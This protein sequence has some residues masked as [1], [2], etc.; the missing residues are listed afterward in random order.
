MKIKSSATGALITNMLDVFYHVS[1]DQLL[2][3]L[4]TE[5]VAD[6]PYSETSPF[7]SM[8]SPANIVRSRKKNKASP[9]KL[10]NFHFLSRYV[11]H[12]DK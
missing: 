12:A 7:P 9:F 3:D 8:S 5:V 1:T 6:A 2:I 11:L 10:V 4:Y